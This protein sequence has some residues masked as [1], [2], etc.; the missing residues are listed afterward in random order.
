MS[1]IAKQLDVGVDDQDR[2][3]FDHFIN[4]DPTK[5]DCTPLEWWCRYEQQRQAYPIRKLSGL[6]SR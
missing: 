3:E 6:M 2:D 5:I 1:T 4:A